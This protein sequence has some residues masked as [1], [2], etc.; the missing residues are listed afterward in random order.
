MKTE[1]FLAV[2]D[3][4]KSKRIV[5]L[6]V[7]A[8]T[9]GILNVAVSSALI[10]GF[11]KF[12]TE[13]IVE[14]FA[15]DLIITPPEGKNYFEN[16]YS[17]K[18]KIENFPEVKKVMP[19]L[20]VVGST[21]KEVKGGLAATLRTEFHLLAIDAK[22]EEDSVIARKIIKGDFLSGGSNEIILGYDLANN[23]DLDV[24]DTLPV[25]IYGKE[26]KFKVVGIVKTGT[27]LIDNI[28]AAI[29]H[30]DIQRITGKKGVFNRIYLKVD[31]KENAEILKY[32]LME[33]GI[34]GKI[35][36]WKEVVSFGEETLNMLSIILFLISGVAILSGSFGVAIML[37]INVLHKTK[38]IG[39][40]RALGAQKRLVINLYILEGLVVGIIGVIVGSVLSVIILSYLSQNPIQINTIKL[41]F[42]LDIFSLIAADLIV[43]IC[44]FVA[45]IYPSY[46]A[47]SI[48]PVE[49]MRY[50]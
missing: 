29:N 48:E 15:G 19:Q 31:K 37:Y 2:K 30:E 10:S 36:T 3:L 24:G 43:L 22:E 42:S 12:F 6:I 7:I 23:L 32:K 8:L 50:E 18:E 4:S 1:F 5:A 46:K 41:R 13:D 38:A 28:Y 34:E 35:S 33:E 17:I 47:A 27:R 39:T 49:A 40:I 9:I 26:E 21:S 25:E 45:S 20:E 16:F 44:V 11:K 14:I